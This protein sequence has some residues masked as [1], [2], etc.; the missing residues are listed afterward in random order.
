MASVRVA[1]IYQVGR[2][3]FPSGE[4]QSLSIPMTAPFGK[5]HRFPISP[6]LNSIGCPNRIP[7]SVGERLQDGSDR[8]A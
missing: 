2:D 6:L 7:A 1:V 3:A 4:A 5:D 8:L